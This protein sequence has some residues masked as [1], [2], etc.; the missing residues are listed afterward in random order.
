M[1]KKDITKRKK[2]EVIYDAQIEG[3]PKKW[4]L[5]KSVLAILLLAVVLLIMLLS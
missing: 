4:K 5:D 3:E 1:A 2:G